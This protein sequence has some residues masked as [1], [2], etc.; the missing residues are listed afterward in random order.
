MINNPNE[1]LIV[2]DTLTKPFTNPDLETF[3]KEIREELKARVETGETIV[4]A[5]AEMK[6][7]LDDQM[8]LQVVKNI[9]FKILSYG[10]EL[11]LAFRAVNAYQ[12]Y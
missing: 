9:K 8:A 3:R 1:A 11:V 10:E 12:K 6:A 4:E 5:L 7:G 2:I